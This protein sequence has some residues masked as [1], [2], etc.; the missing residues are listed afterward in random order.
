MFTQETYKQI[1]LF[2]QYTSK[3]ANLPFVYNG[4][5]KHF[6]HIS[7]K[8]KCWYFFMLAVFS[9]RVCYLIFILVRNMFYGFPKISDAAMEIFYCL[10]CTFVL[11]LHVGFCIY[12]Q[13]ILVILNVLLVT[14]E[15]LQSEFLVQERHWQTGLKYSDGCALFMKLLTPSSFTTPVSFGILFLVQPY[16]RIYFY[17]LLPG[18]KPF[19]LACLYSVPESYYYI[20]GNGLIFFFWYILLLSGNSSTFW[21]Q[22]IG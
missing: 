9:Q 22:Q 10:G 21:L 6:E 4:T 13:E 5:K 2:C 11:L 20:W 12:S 19:W 18:N 17:Y 14:N 7:G 1:K 8:A 3:L 15:A 16:K